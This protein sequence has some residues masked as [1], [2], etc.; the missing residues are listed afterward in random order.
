VQ[1]SQPEAWEVLQNRL[2]SK[3]GRHPA[4]AGATPLGSTR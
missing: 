2:G 1:N 3:A 4:G